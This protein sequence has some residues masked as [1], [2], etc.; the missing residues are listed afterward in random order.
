MSS[1]QMRPR[2]LLLLGS[3]HGVYEFIFAPKS[4]SEVPRFYTRI[5]NSKCKVKCDGVPILVLRSKVNHFSRADNPPNKHVPGSYTLW[6]EV[7]R[8]LL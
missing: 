2:L 6:Q 7:F 4:R 8:W 3:F 5:V 1:M